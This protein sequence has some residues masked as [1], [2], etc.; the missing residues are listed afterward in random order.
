MQVA[1]ASRDMQALHG[2]HWKAGSDMQ[3]VKCTQWNASSGMHAVECKQWNARS[4]MHAV[5]EAHREA[6]IE[7]VLDHI[8]D[9]TEPTLRLGMIQERHHINFGEIVET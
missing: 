6:E 2:K 7:T 4:G 8:A 3:A 5:E 9:A 1:S